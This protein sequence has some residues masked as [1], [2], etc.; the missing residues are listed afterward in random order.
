MPP[1]SSTRLITAAL[2]TVGLE[3][4]LTAVYCVRR[5]SE[6]HGKLLTE[7]EQFLLFNGDLK[8]RLKQTITDGC[9][10]ATTADVPSISCESQQA[11][12]L[13]HQVPGMTRTH[14]RD[15][16]SSQPIARLRD[17]S[18]VRV[19]KNMV[20]VDHVFIATTPTT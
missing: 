12:A 11:I 14:H 5:Q 17:G 15:F 8:D 18:A 19:W 1:C 2:A 20:G 6:P 3:E 4:L 16:K 10:C 9:G 13:L 7:V